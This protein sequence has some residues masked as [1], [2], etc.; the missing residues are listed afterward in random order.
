MP[1]QTKT[2]GIQ[3]QWLFTEYYNWGYSLYAQSSRSW[4]QNSL[5]NFFNFLKEFSHWRG[6]I[7]YFWK[8]ITTSFYCCL[9]ILLS[10]VCLSFNNS[11]HVGH[12]W[13]FPMRVMMDHFLLFLL[14][15]GGVTKGEESLYVNWDINT[16]HE[17]LSLPKFSFSWPKTSYSWESLSCED[18]YRRKR[19]RGFYI[20]SW[21]IIGKQLNQKRN[22]LSIDNCLVLRK[23]SSYLKIR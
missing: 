14:V 17:R 12:D 5:P 8:N 15:Q 3:F 13:K 23:F 6:R 18:T 22:K 20:Y 21:K 19:R 1:T 2:W 16:R 9:C 10:L 7:L 4:S 11:S